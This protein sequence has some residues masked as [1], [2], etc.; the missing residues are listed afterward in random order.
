[1]NLTG[2]AKQYLDKEIKDNFLDLQNKIIETIKQ[3]INLSLNNS[4]K[5]AKIQELNDMKKE[6]NEILE[7]YSFKRNNISN[8]KN[9]YINAIKVEEKLGNS[10]KEYEIELE[11]LKLKELKLNY[12]T[13][14]FNNYIKEKLKDDITSNYKNTNIPITKVP[15]K[16]K[17]L[18]LQNYYMKNKDKKDIIDFYENEDRIYYD[19]KELIKE[20]TPLLFGIFGITAEERDIEEKK[21]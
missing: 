17:A 8:L 14:I 11:K 7:T 16:R 21:N 9:M 1:M 12:I 18:L 2:E 5:E 3:E 6:T 4:I 10:T 20:L 15:D 13:N 19:K